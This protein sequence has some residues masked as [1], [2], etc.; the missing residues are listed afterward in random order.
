MKRDYLLQLLLLEIGRSGR[1]TDLFS[2]GVSGHRRSMSET[3]P[4]PAAVRRVALRWRRWLPRAVFESVLIVFSVVL[5]LMLADWADRRRTAH[6]VAQVRAYF[7]EE[8]RANRAILLSQPILPH[9]RRLRGVFADVDEGAVT[10]EQVTAAYLQVFQTGIHV[11]P[12]RDAVW[13]SAE[14]GDLLGEMPIEELF[15]LAD[16]Y[17]AQAAIG[18]L[19]HGFVGGLPGL[20]SG[21]ENGDGVRAALMAG[22]LH[23]GDVVAGEEGLVRMYDRAL[24]ALDAE[25]QAAAATS[26]DDA[27]AAKG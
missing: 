20:L 8:I 2:G 15:L 16:I 18:G 4:A 17:K 23:L 12:L 21:L 3:Q 14:T 11:P 26:A 6:E 9:H 25:P 19:S 7:V 27:A 1:A 5:A 10:Q 22:Q 24:A 13:R